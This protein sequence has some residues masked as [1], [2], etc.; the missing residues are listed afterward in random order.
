MP[1]NRPT[2]KQLLLAKNLAL[3]KTQREAMIAAGYKV[4]KKSHG[5][6]A[7]IQSPAVQGALAE[8]RQAVKET[9]VYD[10]RAMMDE[11]NEAIEFARETENATAYAKCVELKGKLFGLLIDRQEQR[12]V[13][14]FSIK[15]SGIDDDVVEPT[16]VVDG[17]ATEVVDGG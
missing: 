10:A 2:A 8:F 5:H 3:G 13:G 17:E 16:R 6:T 1:R 11:L 15:F 9:A 14:N 12:Q 4:P 7:L